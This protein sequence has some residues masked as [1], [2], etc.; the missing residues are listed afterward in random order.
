MGGQDSGDAAVQALHHTVGL[1]CALLGQAVLG[2]PGYP[3]APEQAL[4][5]PAS[6]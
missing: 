3:M 1:R 4:L 5:G 2:E 6:G